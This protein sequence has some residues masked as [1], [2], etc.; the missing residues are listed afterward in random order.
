MIFREKGNEEVINLLDINTDLHEDDVKKKKKELN[1]DQSSFIMKL[2]IQ[3]TKNAVE[4]FNNLPKYL[5]E[6][7]KIKTGYSKKVDD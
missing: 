7:T 2:R 1:D 6:L 5:G 3:N 4:L